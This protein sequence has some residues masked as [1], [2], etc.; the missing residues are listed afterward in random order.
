MD[1][2][3]NNPT[4]PT[5]RA[6]SPSTHALTPPSSLKIG[7]DPSV[8]DPIDLQLEAQASAIH[9]HFEGEIQ[10]IKLDAACGRKP[11]EQTPRY[12][13][14]I[15]RELAHVHEVARVRCRWLICFAGY[16]V[17]CDN[18]GL[19][20]AEISRVVERDGGKGG[21]RVTLA[22]WLALLLC[23]WKRREGGKK[24]K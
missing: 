22:V 15:R 13:V 7:I 4:T 20:W 21:Y 18:E 2:L 5:L 10:I 19:A 23:L 12:G 14:Q 16:Q 3:E 6:F 8:A 1:R 11:R 9:N 24:A 17:V